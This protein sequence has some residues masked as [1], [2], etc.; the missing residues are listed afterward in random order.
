MKWG[1][2]KQIDEFA[3]PYL[4]SGEVGCFAL[5]EPGKGNCITCP[6]YMS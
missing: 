3:K 4:N 2:Q 1:T 5:S 6:V